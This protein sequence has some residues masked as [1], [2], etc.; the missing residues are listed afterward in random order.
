MVSPNTPAVPRSRVAG[1]LKSPRNAA[2]GV[3]GQG[4]RK[5]GFEETGNSHDEAVPK[6]LF[7]RVA[8]VPRVHVAHFTVKGRVMTPILIV[9]TLGF[10][11][12]RASSSLVRGAG[13]E[14]AIYGLGNRCFVLLS[15]SRI[16]RGA[17]CGNRTRVTGLGSPCSATE[18]RTHVGFCH[19]RYRNP[20]CSITTMS[21]QS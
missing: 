4:N 14:P 1:S 10:L 15:Y 8:L 12:F 21:G 16:S 20:H 6:G 2:W 17:S 13:L 11:S 7:I 3:V 19:C 9:Y 18:L 5:S